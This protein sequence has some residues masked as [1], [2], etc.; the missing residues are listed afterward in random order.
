MRAKKFLSTPRGQMP[1]GVRGAEEM[2]LKIGGS[3]TKD[4]SEETGMKG[5]GRFW[6]STK[7]WSE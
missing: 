5:L 2:L 1:Q 3:R 7:S 6:I 4:V